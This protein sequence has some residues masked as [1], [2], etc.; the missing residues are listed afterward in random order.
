MQQCIQI[1]TRINSSSVHTYIFVCFI[2]N[3]FNNSTW[4]QNRG[5]SYISSRRRIYRSNPAV[6][7]ISPSILNISTVE[8]QFYYS[9]EG[10]RQRSVQ[11]A[12]GSRVFRAVLPG[13]IFILGGSK[14]LQAPHAVPRA[15]PCVSKHSKRQRGSPGSPCAVPHATKH[16]TRQKLHSMR[17]EVSSRSLWSSCVAVE[18]EF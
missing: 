1:S 8:L 18:E 14:A 3:L 5:C 13:R 16:S 4:C 2:Q 9:K 11:S 15:V 7:C 17:P 10:G 6:S 12:I